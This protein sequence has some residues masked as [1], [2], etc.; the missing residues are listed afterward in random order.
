MTASGERPSDTVARR[1]QELR[2][3]RG[4]SVARLADQC[5][6]AGA[7]ELTE[8]VLTNI[9]TRRRRPGRPRDVTIDEVVALARAL[10]VPPVGLWWASSDP[11]EHELLLRFNN[12]EDL[13]DFRR[14]AEPLMER[15]YG[16]QRDADHGDGGG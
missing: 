2:R 14:V 1:V 12:E 13:E 15:L 4:W 3:R 11:I 16:R 8:S 6:Q 9:L 5:A 7:P 10:D